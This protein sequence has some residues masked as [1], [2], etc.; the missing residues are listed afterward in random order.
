MK[1]IA[2]SLTGLLGW[3]LLAATPCSAASFADPTSPYSGAVA[4]P[5]SGLQ[6]VLISGQRKLAVIDGRR[7]GVGDR[8]GQ[9]VVTDIQP[10]RVLLRRG[11]QT[12]TLKLQSQAIKY[13]NRVPDHGNQSLPAP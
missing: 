4:M 8:V 3:L 9:A 10:Y 5:T 6:S 13:N 7:V 12:I 2:M 1:P 11:D